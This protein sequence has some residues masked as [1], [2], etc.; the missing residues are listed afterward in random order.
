MGR[1][2][3]ISQR[4]GAGHRQPHTACTARGPR[5]ALYR[6]LLKGNHSLFREASGQPQSS[7]L[8]LP[9]PSPGLTRPGPH[10]IAQPQTPPAAVRSNSACL[11]GAASPLFAEAWGP[12]PASTLPA[13]GSQQPALGESSRDQSAWVA[14]LPLAFLSGICKMGAASETLQTR[15]RKAV[16]KGDEAKSPALAQGRLLL[17]LNPLRGRWPG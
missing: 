1:G 3:Q 10:C 14:K 9:P 6:E 7:C 5:P 11:G 13:G 12:T 8:S 4:R 15:L 16:G 2:I 17:V